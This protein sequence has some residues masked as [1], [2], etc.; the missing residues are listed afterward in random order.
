MVDELAGFVVFTSYAQLSQAAHAWAN[1]RILYALRRAIRL[2]LCA[3]ESGEPR[4]CGVE[5]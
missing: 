2:K 4:A 5:S 3:L 1:I